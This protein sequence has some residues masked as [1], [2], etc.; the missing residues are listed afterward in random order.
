MT[1]ISDSTQPYRPLAYSL[2]NRH[3]GENSGLST[4]KLSSSSRAATAAAM[5]TYAAETEIFAS[6]LSDA[7]ARSIGPV[8]LSSFERDVVTNGAFRTCSLP[9]MSTETPDAGSSRQAGGLGVEVAALRQVGRAFGRCQ[10]GV[11]CA[12]RRSPAIS[13]RC[14]R[15]ACRR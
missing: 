5:A 3:A 9:Q 14:A 2:I 1:N 11:T 8:L 7:A 13:C 4:C 15:T 12:L 6:A 10:V